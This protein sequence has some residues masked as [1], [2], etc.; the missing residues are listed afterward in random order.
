MD[1]SRYT[2]KAQE[3]IL[4]AQSLAEEHN[5][6]QIE[7]DHLLL[8]LLRQRDGVVPQVIIGLILRCTGIVSNNF[9]TAFPSN[10]HL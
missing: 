9:P 10:V 4:A 1:L 3:A 6:S 7:P 2:Q 5:H 8:A